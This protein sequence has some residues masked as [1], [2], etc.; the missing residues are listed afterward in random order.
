VTHVTETSVEGRTIR[1][2]NL[3]KVLYPSAHFTKAAVVDYYFRI[4]PFLLPHLRGRPITLKRFPDGVGGEAFFEKNCPV[5][6]PPWVKTAGVWSKHKQADTNYCLIDDLPTLIWVANLAAIE[7]H[8]SLSR[9]RSM[10][11]PTALAFDLDPGPPANVVTCARVALLLK[12]MLGRVR[13][14][15]FPKTSGSKGLQVYVPLNSKVSYDETKAY[16]RA[17]A[18]VLERQQ[19]KLVL[20]NMKKSLRP[21]KVFVDWSQN[22]EHKTTVAV[23]SLRAR[24]RPTVSTPITWKEVEHAVARDRTDNLVFEADRA[25]ERA[26]RMGDLFEPVLKRKQTLPR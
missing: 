13:L 21:G 4:A 24:E 14:E 22:D 2:T 10:A 26:R 11:R 25:I 15:G 17:L 23:Y 12:E 19:P 3:D 9:A 5:F 6:R 1:M 18:E 8:P 20:S 7:L 16:A